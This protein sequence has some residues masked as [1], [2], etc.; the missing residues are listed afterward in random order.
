MNA[1]KSRARKKDFIQR[2]TAA[3]AGLE[4]E[5][6][7]LDRELQSFGL[8]AARVLAHGVNGVPLEEFLRH[9]PADS[10]SSKP[11]FLPI[12]DEDAEEPSGPGSV[13]L[14]RF[15]PS[16]PR[17]HGSYRGAEDEDEDGE[18]DEF[19]GDGKLEGEFDDGSENED[20]EDGEDGEDDEDDED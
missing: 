18:E 12:F 7:R 16:D 1:R 13:S 9:C 15:G 4:A 20:D 8:S 5:K 11:S 17:T 10:T 14:L 3:V 19:E 2:L 6:A